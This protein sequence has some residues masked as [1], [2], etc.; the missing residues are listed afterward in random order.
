MSLLLLDEPLLALVPAPRSWEGE[1]RPRWIS[2]SAPGASRRTTTT[3]ESCGLATDPVGGPVGKQPSR[4]GS[5]RSA[6]QHVGELVLTLSA[7]VGL[8]VMG[9][10]VTAHLTGLRPLVVKSGSMEPTIPTGAMVLVRSIPAAEI[11]VDDVVAVTRPDNTRVTH[12]VLDVV[13]RGVAAELVLKGDANEDPDPVPVT[14]TEAGRL[15][16][17]VPSIGRVSAFFASAKGGFMLGCVFT[18]AALPVL[19]RRDSAS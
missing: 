9:I 3:S 7:L 14:V 16:M 8:V 19:R 2:A 6:G 17:S 4:T 1:G 11:E 18:A 5:R 13:Q 15:V 10:T 12:R